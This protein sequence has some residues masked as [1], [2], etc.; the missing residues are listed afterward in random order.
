MRVGA[1]HG[2]CRC[3]REF[4]KSDRKKWPSE[5]AGISP[6]FG[7]E[8]SPFLAKAAAENIYKT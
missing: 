8:E 3:C 5:M 2:L 6:S 4:L 7:G 1:L